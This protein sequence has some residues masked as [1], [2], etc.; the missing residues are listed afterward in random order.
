MFRV[1]VVARIALVGGT[2]CGGSTAVQAEAGAHDGSEPPVQPDASVAIDAA[3][4]GGPAESDGASE[5]RSDAADT[6][7]VSSDCASGER[8]LYK[9]GDCSAKGECLSLGL[10]CNIA[11]GCSGCSDG[12]IVEGLCDQ[13]SYAYGPALSCSP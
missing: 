1:L 2:V 9:V 7:T 13:P 5:A 12:H 10:V 11:V 3:T 6:C 8:C 4:E